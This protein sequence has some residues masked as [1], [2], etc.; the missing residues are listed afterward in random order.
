MAAAASVLL[1]GIPFTGAGGFWITT[2]YAIFARF[3]TRRS[4]IG[5]RPE[6]WSLEPCAAI[7]FVAPPFEQDALKDL[8]QIGRMPML[9]AEHH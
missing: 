5:L 7:S 3:A 1:L 9:G 6:S 2:F 4:V 8:G